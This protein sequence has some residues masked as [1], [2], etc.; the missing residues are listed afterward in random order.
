MPCITAPSGARRCQEC[1][2][3][4]AQLAARLV[5]MTKLLLI[6]IVCAAL[7]VLALGGWTVRGARGV[8]KPA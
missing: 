6:G 8:L 1:V 4:D 7:L 3:E 5:G 2:T